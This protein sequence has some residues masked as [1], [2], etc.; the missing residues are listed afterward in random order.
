MI[1][2]GLN[3]FNSLPPN[4]SLQNRQFIL[5]EA[6]GQ[7]GFGIIYRGDDMRLHRSVAIKEF[8]PQGCL[9]QEKNVSPCG[10][11]TTSEYNG[12]KE[13]F[14][15][16]ARNLAKFNH[17]GIVQVHTFFE[18]NNTAY[19][20]MEY[21]RGN[22]LLRLLER[23]GP[24]P[25]NDVVSYVER[26]SDALQELHDIQLLHQDI[27]PENVMVCEDG[28]VVMIDFGLTK[29]IEN[30]GGLGTMKL[31]ATTQFGS[32]GY[33]PPEQYIKSASVGTYT[34]IYALGATLYHLLTG[35]LPI[36]ATERMYGVELPSIRQFQP[37]LSR[38]LDQAI[39]WAMELKENQRPQNLSAFLQA[40]NSQFA[41]TSVPKNLKN[42]LA[43]KANAEQKNLKIERLCQ[44]YEADPQ[45]ILDAVKTII[46]P[47]GANSW[48]HIQAAAFLHQMIR[49]SVIQVD[50]EGWITKDILDEYTLISPKTGLPQ[51]LYQLLKQR[52][53][54]QESKR[55]SGSCFRL[56]A[57]NILR[58]RDRTSSS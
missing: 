16:E 15:D 57:A 30:L 49:I 29:K 4:A 56:K 2:S 7:G 54:I 22:T 1:N 55:R 37:L 48:N 10:T 34:D 51:P 31:R 18:E 9:R 28:R 47:K 27:K 33:S 44:L 21:L 6:I 38:N 58:Q 50:P 25:E 32:E 53:L 46:S 19:M 52:D 42:T 45:E 26:I 40:L 5:R 8:F 20:V 43:S 17:P 39:A 36:S 14:M 3:L 35:E 41:N 24:I 13:K 11:L 23:Q 12:L